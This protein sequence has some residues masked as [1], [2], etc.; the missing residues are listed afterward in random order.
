M[1]HP[2]RD[3]ARLTRLL[4]LGAIHDGAQKLAD[5]AQRLEISNQS[6]GGHVRAL[7]D[8]G[9]VDAQMH[10]TPAGRQWLIDE[11][12]IT[13][14]AA[15]RIAAGASRL[16]VVSARAAV[17][18]EAGMR[19]GLRMV[20]GDLEAAP[21]PAESTGVVRIGAQAG[22]EVVVEGLQGVVALEP[23]T[24]TL[25]VVPGPAEGGAGR[26]DGPRPAGLVAALGTG[27]WLAAQDWGVD[28][29]F[30]PVEGALNAAQ[31]GLDVT[32]VVSRDRLAEALASLD[33]CGVP[34]RQEA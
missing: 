1:S 17:D 22:A 26:C 3:P 7:R 4:V 5:I 15:R 32:L 11:A 21:G 19:V 10:V 23:G 6:A 27:A 2:L 16:R 8:A 20:E 9:H 14:E 24:I 29:R 33:G 13:Q 18:L 25:H 12:R 28:V 31:R 30:A 34:V